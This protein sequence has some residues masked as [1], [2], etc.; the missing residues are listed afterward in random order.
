MD[1]LDRVLAGGVVIAGDVDLTIAN[2][3]LVTVNLR[4][5]IDLGQQPRGAAVRRRGAEPVTGSGDPRVAGGPGADIAA[6][7]RGSDIQILRRG[8]PRRAAPGHPQA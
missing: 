2:V 6:T 5:L 4:G 1:L 3:D 8:L 7:T